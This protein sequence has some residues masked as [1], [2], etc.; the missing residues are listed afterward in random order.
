MM[1][2]IHDRTGYTYD[3]IASMWINGFL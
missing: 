3:E 1:K 2:T